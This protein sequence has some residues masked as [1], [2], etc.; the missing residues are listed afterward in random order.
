MKKHHVAAPVGVI[1][2]VVGVVGGWAGA[3]S[4]ATGI[5]GH[6]CIWPTHAFLE[7]TSTGKQYIAVEATGGAGWSENHFGPYSVPAHNFVNSLQEDAQSGIVDATGSI[8]S[9]GW[10]CSV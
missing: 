4:A 8:S 1:A 5:G 2:V 9:Y 3:A 10:G 7:M 6:D